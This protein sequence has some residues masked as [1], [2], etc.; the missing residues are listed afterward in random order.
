MP[1]EEAVER[2]TIQSRP[3]SEVG[4]DARKHMQRL[5]A[6]SAVRHGSDI[7][8]EEATSKEGGAAAPAPTASTD[9]DGG[10]ALVAEAMELD[11]CLYDLGIEEV[12]ESHEKMMGESL[13]GKVDLFC[14]YRPCKVRS[15]QNMSKSEY[16][17]FRNTDMEDMVDLIQEVMKKGSLGH[18]FC[19]E[20][21]FGL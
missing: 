2:G 12:V 21:Q 1:E 19:S 16:D 14:T 7:D 20:L 5:H 15:C 3:T 18:V 13:D 4:L 17:A 6:H 10:Y 8:L 9:V 11:C